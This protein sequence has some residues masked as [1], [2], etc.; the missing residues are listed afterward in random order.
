MIFHFCETLFY[1]FSYLCSVKTVESPK[2]SMKRLIN[3]AVGIPLLFMVS[4]NSGKS[5]NDVASSDADSVAV[6]DSIM[7]KK[8]GIITQVAVEQEQVMK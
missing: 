1:I 8:D 5:P 2:T 4:C 7:M 6:T 3:I